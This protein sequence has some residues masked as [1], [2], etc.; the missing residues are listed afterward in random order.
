MKITDGRV[1]ADFFRDMLAG[2]DLVLLSDG[3]PTRTFC[4]VADAIT[5]YYLVLLRGPP[6][7]PYNVGIDG[8]EISMLDL[9]EMVAGLAATSSATRGRWSGARVPRRTTWSTTPIG[10][11][12]TSPRPGTEL[13]V[14]TAR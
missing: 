9:A 12:R 14:P 8:P 5:G 2:R 13:R 7:E 3:S 1:I 11:A 6:G 4:Y 10:A